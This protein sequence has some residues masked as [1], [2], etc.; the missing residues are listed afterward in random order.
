MG[1]NHY[2]WNFMFCVEW[3]CAHFLLIVGWDGCRQARGPSPFGLYCCK[4]SA[5]RVHKLLER[6]DKIYHMMWV[7]VSICYRE[8]AGR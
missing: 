4:L 5:S 1:S 6:S 8:T 7:Y 3:A 2:L